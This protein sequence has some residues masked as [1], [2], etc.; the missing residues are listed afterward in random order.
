[1]RPTLLECASCARPHDPDVPQGVCTACGK[2]LLARYDLDGGAA[3]L[4]PGAS[5]RADLWR[6]L[7][8]L[9][10][11]S[12]EE[13]V[14][15]G[16]GWTPVLDAP[17]LARWAGL[18]RCLVKDE[19]VN[20]T[21]SFKAR[22]MAVATA[23]A[24]R[25]GIRSVFVPSAGNAGGAL[26]AY[27]ARAGLR[28]TVAMPE[29]APGVNQVE[30]RAAGAETVLVRGTIADA[31]AALRRRFAGSDAFDLSTLREPYRVEGKK[32][33]GYEL[34][35]QLGR[36]PD[37]IVYPCGGGTGIVGMWKAFEEMERLG[38]IG[39]ERPR[40]AIVQSEGCA[41]LVR[42]FEEGKTEAAPFPDPATC[43]AGLRVPSAIGDF[44]VLR[45]VR[46]SGGRAV[47]V[48]EAEI[49]EAT[50]VFFSSTGIG[51]CPEGG[52]ALAG[53]RRLVVAGHVGA[54]DEVVLFNTASGL[55]YPEVLEAA[56]RA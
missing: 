22:G 20:P 26:A 44:L 36:L 31:A 9:P 46:A 30:C 52:A 12:E 25:L 13:I 54:A 14:T 47:A 10:V 42:A 11:A 29:D 40:M 43:A 28:A 27:A 21:G 3:G 37:W 5:A 17:P 15:L 2:P 41:P 24:R 6:Y 45:A 51:A 8:V 33:M 16:E 38:W 18:R 50:R 34:F 55:K 4:R 39:S 53:L 23:V 56:L 49:L 19:A 48:R 35:E 7:A 32:T 1:V